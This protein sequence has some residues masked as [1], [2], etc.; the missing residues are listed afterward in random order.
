MATACGACATV[1]AD[2]GEQ[3]V[4]DKVGTGWARA[5]RQARHGARAGAGCSFSK[6]SVSI[7]V[8]AW[9]H[10]RRWRLRPPAGRAPIARIARRP[11]RSGGPRTTLSRPAPKTRS[12]VLASDKSRNS[13]AAQHGKF[14]ISNLNAS[15]TFSERAMSQESRP[16]W[17]ITGC[18]TGFGRELSKILLAEGYCV[19]VTARDPAKIADLVVDHPRNGP[20]AGAERGR[21]GADRGFGRGGD[22]EIRQHRCAGEQCRLWLHGGGRGRRGRRNSRHVRDQLLRSGRHE[23]RRSARHAGAKERNHRQY[24]LD[25][26]RLRLPRHRLL[27]CDQIRGRGP[28]RGHGEGACAARRQSPDRR[29][30]PVPHRLG[31]A[32]AENAET[33]D[34]RLCRDGH[35]AA[36]GDSGL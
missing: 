22:E 6:S 21:S 23:P 19:V 33:G 13:L 30:R 15:K 9:S 35:S 20:G 29:A 26:R 31:R 17:L 1:A 32:L 12:C 18:S 34:R 28:V 8:I 5:P 11:T 24:F 3:F 25:G 16:V 4:A 10:S 2:F 36:Q 27:Q 14:R 7:S